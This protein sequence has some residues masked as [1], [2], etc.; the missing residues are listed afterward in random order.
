MRTLNVPEAESGPIRRP[1]CRRGAGAL[2]PALGRRLGRR[3]GVDQHLHALPPAEP[4]RLP[5][6]QRPRRKHRL[7]PSSATTR[8][9][10]PASSGIF[11]TRIRRPDGRPHA[12]ARTSTA[13]PRDAVLDAAERAG[14]LDRRTAAR[15]PAADHRRAGVSVVLSGPLVLGWWHAGQQPVAGSHANSQEP[16]HDAL[17]PTSA[18]SSGASCSPRPALR[19]AVPGPHRPALAA[20]QRA[21]VSQPRRRP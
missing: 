19:A 20:Q 16:S 21:D 9:P 18:S 3:P 8:S 17:H 15:G 4:R 10:S 5:R 12:R 2:R 1:C 13:R 7:R 14:S 6:H 11:H